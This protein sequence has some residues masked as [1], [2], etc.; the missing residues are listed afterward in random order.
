MYLS[1][2]RIKNFR[3]LGEFEIEF[4]QGL[5]V[6]VGENNV[7]KTNLF[8]AIRIALGPGIAPGRNRL[9]AS[10]TDLHRDGDGRVAG[11]FEIRLIF[12]DINLSEMSGLI[13]CLAYD[14]ANPANSK[15][16]INYRWAWNEITQ[17]YSQEW[18]GGET[19]ND[20]G[21]A[22]E[23]MQNIPV[24]YLE[25][26]RDAQAYLTGGRNSRIGALLRQLSNPQEQK[27]L[28][29]L[30]KDRND[31]LAQHSLAKNALAAIQNNLRS[32]TSDSLA[33]TIGLVPAKAEFDAIANSL[34]MILHL[35]QSSN[36]NLFTEAEISENG[37]G[38]NNL[39]YI[40]TVLAELERVKPGETPLLIVE[41]PEAH[42]HPQLQ[43][44][45]ADF[46][47]KQ[48]QRTTE[49]QD[50]GDLGFDSTA[51]EKLLPPQI[52]ITT[53]SPTLAAHFPPNHLNVVHRP[54][55][56][57]RNLKA[58]AIWNCGLDQNELRKL[59]R[60][61]DVT[62]ATMF[63]ARGVILVE[64]IC[65]QLLL[66]VF[67][68]RLGMPL[69][70][71]AISII[72]VHGV[73]FQ[74]ILKIF[75]GNG[76]ELPCAII[77]DADPEKEDCASLIPDQDAEYF[78][79]KPRLG[80]ISGQ[81]QNLATS[82]SSSTIVRVYHSQVTLEYEL[83]WVA[84]NAVTMMEIGKSFLPQKFQGVIADHLARL[85][86][87]E[88]KACLVWQLLCERDNGKCKAPFAHE[89]TLALAGQNPKLVGFQVPE[90][91]CNAIQFVH[92][93]VVR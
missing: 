48:S 84:D 39:L 54:W 68:Q 14:K 78:K 60:L 26:L 90:Y 10:K 45:L 89:L 50:L 6:I 66:P 20:N 72:P 70:D 73:N 22:G 93:N 52:F 13:E 5:N 44:L 37:L 31:Q 4:R 76:L 43:S 64:G 75:S 58:A 23:V 62:K 83:A 86:T 8:D 15:L 29:D 40:A 18:W 71:E 32:A 2:V 65:E 7:G 80:E 30:F 77:T 12:S 82:V 87:P 34:R 49:R 27:E 36:P 57:P 81:T 51:A 41:E 28:E 11:F 69:A 59:Q 46:L 88:D 61:L 24:T 42:L 21:L 9:Y 63:F 85:T 1:H 25:P 35:K 33:Q 53:H 67:S 47:L 56:N 79:K 55:S 38:Y 17:R 19:K 91:I 3:N 74:T 16:I 92:A